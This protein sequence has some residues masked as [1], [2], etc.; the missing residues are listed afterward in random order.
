M[1]DRNRPSESKGKR[2]AYVRNKAKTP[3]QGL[4]FVIGKDKLSDVDS[5]AGEIADRIIE[6]E[7]GRS[8]ERN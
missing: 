8:N 1:S 3:G 2:S 6:Y 5:L 7:K 4:R